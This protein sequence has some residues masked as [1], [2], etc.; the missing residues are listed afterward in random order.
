MK[1]ESL[2]F[3]R[4][5]NLHASVPCMQAVLALDHGQLTQSMQD[6]LAQVLPSPPLG[7]SLGDTV[8]LMVMALQRLAGSPVEFSQVSALTGQGGHYQLVCA[9]ACEP[10]AEA[11]LD[12]ALAMLQ[13][14][15]DGHA[16]DPATRLAAFQQ[17]A[18]RHAESDAVRQLRADAQQ[19]GIPLLEREGSRMLQLGWGSAQR[20]VRRDQAGHANPDSLFGNGNGR[21]PVIAITGTNGK[22]TTTRL[23]GHAIAGT[24]ARV[25]MTTT[26][27]VI[28]NGQMVSEGDCTGYQSARKVLAS[29]DVDFAVLEQ[30]RGGILK[31]G[32][33]F[34]RSDVAVVLNVSADHLGMDGVETLEDMARVKQVVANTA[35]RVLVLNAEDAHCVAIGRQAREHVEIFYFSLDAENPELVRHL[36]AG[37]RAL[38]LQEQTMVLAD[39]R[40]HLALCDA[41][42]LPVTLAGAARYNIANALAAASALVAAGVKRSA[43]VAGLASF[44]SDARS[45][46]MRS[47]IIDV[48][49]ITVVFDFAHN[50]AAYTALAGMARHLATGKLVG[51]VSAP[52]DRRDEDLRQIGAVCAAG[53]DHLVIYESE[54]RG[55]QQGDTARLLA[56]GAREGGALH[57][58]LHCKLDV[59]R[60]IRFGLAMCEPGDVMVFGCASSLSELIEAI[61]P[62]MPEIAERIAAETLQTA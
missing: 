32:L 33:G 60:A 22:T 4:G 49:G 2:R 27:G 53:F 40:R 44:V 24:G 52:G 21:I 20:R 28:I 25:G 42:R 62:D 16:P 30:A 47:N 31:R 35:A 14:L 7:A 48:A 10:V 58:R 54:N 46:P 1:L 56:Q 3:L 34:D 6:R 5:P 26:E 41:H 18:Q 39:G 8:R 13:A 43:I 51:V 37:G 11:A 12:T 45:N 23:I 9:Y 36:A 61:R 29:P 15:A 19:R 57:G 50:S 55:R 17:L 38:Y 59:H